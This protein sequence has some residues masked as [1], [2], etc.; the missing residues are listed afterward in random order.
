LKRKALFIIN[1]IAGGKKKDGVPDLID[2]NLDKDVFDYDIIF[3]DGVSHAQQI[4]AEAAG[5]FDEVVWPL[6]AM[7]RLT[8]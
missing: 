5:K 2:Q 4:A 1:P 3:T 8:K 7:V 6:G